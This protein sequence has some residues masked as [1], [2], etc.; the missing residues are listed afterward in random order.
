MA[1]CFKCEKPILPAVVGENMTWES[2]QGVLFQDAGN[3]GSSL[4]DSIVNGVFVHIIVCDDCLKAAQ[5]TDRMKE[6]SRV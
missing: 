6:E 3:F 1:S 4:Y 2:P 5:G